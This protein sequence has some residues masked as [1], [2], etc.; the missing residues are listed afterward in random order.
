[1]KIRNLLGV[2]CVAFISAGCG[3]GKVEDAG[4]FTVQ[5]AGITFNANCPGGFLNE[6]VS[7]HTINGGLEP[8][9][10]RPTS[11]SLEVG[12]VNADGD[13]VPIKPNGGD[14][15]LKGRDPEFAI[16]ARGLGCGTDVGVL[17]LDDRSAIVNVSVKVESIDK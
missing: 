9:R 5:P 1:M 17:V 11:P 8:F 4:G 3:G 15:T 2:L 16:R 14:L 12:L 13:F 6:E 7:V 10:L